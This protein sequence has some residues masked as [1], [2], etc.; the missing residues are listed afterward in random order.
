MQPDL[1]AS[2]A[3]PL[4]PSRIV[5]PPPPPPARPTRHYIRASPPREAMQAPITSGLPSQFFGFNHFMG[6][7]LPCTCALLVAA[8]AHSLSLSALHVL[9][10]S[11]QSIVSAHV[12]SSTPVVLCHGARPNALLE[13]ITL[14]VFPL[15]LACHFLGPLA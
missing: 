11:L 1:R 2:R 12:H 14:V 4:P 13:P 15:H 3:Q 7:L 10:L 8:H 6:G 9:P 5:P